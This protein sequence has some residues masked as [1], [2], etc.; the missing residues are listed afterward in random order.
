MSIRI[1]N[2]LLRML[3]NPASL[4]IHCSSFFKE[5]KLFL[6]RTMD[7]AK[8]KIF[9]WVTVE[10]FIFYFLPFISNW[11]SCIINISSC[12]ILFDPKISFDYLLKVT[13]QLNGKET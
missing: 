8:D 12:H 9:S 3:D 7:A 4:S 10:K 13:F 11:L 6:N 2:N 5:L 1:S